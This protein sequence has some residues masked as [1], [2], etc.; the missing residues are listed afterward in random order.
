[1]SEREE[2]ALTIPIVIF[3]IFRYWYVVEQKKYGESP[4]DALFKDRQLMLSVG[5]WFL[6]SAFLI[7]KWRIS[8][9]SHLYILV[10]SKPNEIF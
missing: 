3:G 2:L 6:L 9:G 10:K 1:L 8:T 5:I 7:K 4:T